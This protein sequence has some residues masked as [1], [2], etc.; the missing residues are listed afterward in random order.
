MGALMEGPEWVA[1]H[2]IGMVA[3]Q[4]EGGPSFPSDSGQSC[5]Q[6]GRGGCDWRWNR[7]SRLH[8]K[9]LMDLMKLGISRN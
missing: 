5:D 8:L 1:Q 7:G 9:A 2:T 4:T 3:C 6:D